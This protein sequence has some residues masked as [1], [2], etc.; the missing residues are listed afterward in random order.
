MN[1]VHLMRVA[2]GREK[3]IKVEG[4]YHGHHD[5]CSSRCTRRSR[6]PAR[7]RARTRCATGAGDPRGAR[8]RSRS[9]VPFGDL[10]AVERV[11]AENPGEIAG[12]MLEPAMMNISIIPPP[13]GYLAGLQRAAATPTARCSRSTR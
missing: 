1:A 7:S 11:L 8:A 3:I 10:E 4:T 12:M 13:D 5:T 9:I 2:T 6:K